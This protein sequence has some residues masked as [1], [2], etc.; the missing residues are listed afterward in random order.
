MPVRTPGVR[1]PDF[2]MDGVAWEAKAPQTAKRQT[3]EHVFAHAAKQSPFVIF[4]L[5]AT[6]CKTA[7]SLLEFKFEKSKR[8]RRMKII[9][10]QSHLLEYDK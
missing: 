6:K 5:R 7:Q 4:D 3:I 1:S 2:V 8:V 9:T 10:K